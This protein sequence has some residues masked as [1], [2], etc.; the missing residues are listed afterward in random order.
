MPREARKLSESGFYHVVFRGINHQDI[1]EEE[2]DFE[3]MLEIF[4]VLKQEIKF[5]VHAYCLMTNH[6]HILLK[7]NQPGDISIIL[8]RL[9]IKYVMKFNRK[10]QRNGALIG[11]RYKSKVVEVDEYFIPLIVYIHQNPMRAGIVQKLENYKYSSYGEYIGKR[12]IVDTNLSLD[13]LGKKEW[14]KAHQQMVENKFEVEGR[15]KLS[16]EEI[17]KKISKI[18]NNIVPQKIETMEK[19]ERDK[20]LR[21]LKNEGLSIRELERA[22]GISRGIIAKS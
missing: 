14:V 10:Y 4:K 16:G 18:A 22:T 3:Y 17:R 15:K 1:F 7:E 13:I 11:S 9:L 5:E 20:I 12:D 21:Q 2:Q 19:E 8:K 6:V